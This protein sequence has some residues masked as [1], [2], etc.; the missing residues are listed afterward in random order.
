MSPRLKGKVAIV[1]GASKG[2]GAAAPSGP[3]WRV[4]GTGRMHPTWRP[5]LPGI[6]PLLDLAEPASA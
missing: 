6:D 4:L 5:Y 1:T 3:A 2:I